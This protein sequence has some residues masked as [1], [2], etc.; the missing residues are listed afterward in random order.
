MNLKAHPR[1]G[2]DDYR[3]AVTV[4]VVSSLAEDCLLLGQVLRLP[5]FKSFKLL[6]VPTCRDARAIL[7]ENFVPV[8]IS[9]RDLS[10]GCWKDVLCATGSSTCRPHL[11][12][13]S[14]AADA[15][16]WAEVLNLGGYDVLAKPFDATEVNRVLEAALQNWIWLK[17]SQA[18]SVSSQ[19]HFAQ[20]VN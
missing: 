19:K 10:D 16:L 17:M 3:D 6:G 1:V 20:Q 12:V 14:L 2:V 7:D 13:T 4:L 15:H 5:S 11:I 18:G 9:D 8:V